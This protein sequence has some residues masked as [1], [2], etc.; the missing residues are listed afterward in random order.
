MKVVGA[1]GDERV[2]RGDMLGPNQVL[3]LEVCLWA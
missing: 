1:D 3:R 2:S